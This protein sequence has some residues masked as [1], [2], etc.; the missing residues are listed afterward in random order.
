MTFYAFRIA[1]V[2]LDQVRRDE[3]DRNGNL[4]TPLQYVCHCF[5]KALDLSYYFRYGLTVEL[6]NASGVLS[7]LRSTKYLCRKST[8]RAKSASMLLEAFVVALF[9]FVLSHTIK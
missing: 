3:S 6:L 8:G 9:I 2:W 5:F 4:P 7:L 1:H